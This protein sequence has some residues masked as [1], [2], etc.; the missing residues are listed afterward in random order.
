LKNIDC[1][2]EFNPPKL[3]NPPTLNSKHPNIQTNKLYP[4]YIYLKI[5]TFSFEKLEVW[6]ESRT[7]VRLIYLQTNSFSSEEKFG[8]TSQLRRAAI[9]VGSNIA[10]GAGRETV[11]NQCQFY[12]MAYGSLM[13]VLNQL[14]I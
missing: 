14:I 4:K 9:S 10:E 7:L 3:P 6:K 8:L 13:E 1:R 5:T 2:F 11:K 12:V